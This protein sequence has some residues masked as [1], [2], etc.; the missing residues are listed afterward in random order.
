M[1]AGITD[2]H[3]RC[4]IFECF[5]LNQLSGTAVNRASK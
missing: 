5:R 4:E 2:H 1:E 3:H